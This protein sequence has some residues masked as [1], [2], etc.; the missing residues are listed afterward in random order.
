MAPTEKPHRAL[1]VTL[2][3]RKTS[4]APVKPVSWSGLRGQ[5]GGV[6]GQPCAIPLP[7][8]AFPCHLHRNEG[9]IG[10][11]LLPAGMGMVVQVGWEGHPGGGC[12]HLISGEQKVNCLKVQSSCLLLLLLRV[13]REGEVTAGKCPKCPRDQMSPLCQ[14]LGHG[15]KLGKAPSC[16]ARGAVPGQGCIPPGEGSKPAE[17][18]RARRGTGT[19]NA[20]CDTADPD[21]PSAQTHRATSPWHSHVSQGQVHSKGEVREP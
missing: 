20:G 15:T 14:P 8:P 11:G 10:H 17:R 1:G 16:W 21:P 19:I 5:Q 18:D 4:R 7:A 13:L 6:Q 3:Q 9:K 2:G 12:S